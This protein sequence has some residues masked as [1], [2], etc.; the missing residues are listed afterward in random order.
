MSLQTLIERNGML[1]RSRYESVNMSSQ[2]NHIALTQQLVHHRS[3]IDVEHLD[4][5]KVFVTFDHSLLSDKKEEFW[6]ISL[7]HR[8]THTN[9]MADLCLHGEK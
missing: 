5:S 7:P 2:I 6:I 1:T 3:T 4:F 9:F 8:S